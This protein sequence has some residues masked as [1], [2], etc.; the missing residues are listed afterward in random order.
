[1][2][3]AKYLN[4]IL[5]LNAIAMMLLVAIFALDRGSLVRTAS[6]SEQQTGIPDAAS[7]RLEMIRELRRMNAGLEALRKDLEKREFSVKVLSMPAVR[8]ETE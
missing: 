2:R 4:T 6:A 8:V 7:Q 3:R 1:M 5:T